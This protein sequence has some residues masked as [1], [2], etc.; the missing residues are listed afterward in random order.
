MTGSLVFASALAIS[1][2]VRVLSISTAPYVQLCY[3]LFL[4]VLDQE[5][6]CE[7]ENNTSAESSPAERKIARPVSRARASTLAGQRSEQVHAIAV[8]IEHGRIA[9]TPEGVERGA[10]AG[11]ACGD[12][13]VM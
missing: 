3:L 1:A 12:Q 2:P 10:Q 6:D 7:V 13:L 11:V 8:G 9:L 4:A 5:G